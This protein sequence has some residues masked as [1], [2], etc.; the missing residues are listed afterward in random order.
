[1]RRWPLLVASLALLSLPWPAAAEIGTIDKVPAATLLFPYFEVDVADPDGVNTLIGIQNTS[2]TAAL[3]HVTLWTDL[4]YPTFSWN[5]YLTGYDQETIDLR[6]LFVGRLVPITASDGQDPPDT[7]SPQG[8]FSQD[9]NF[10]TCSG[11]PDDFGYG[12]NGPMWTMPAYAPALTPEWA[13]DLRAAHMGLASPIY[14]HGVC[15]ARIHGDT[16]ARGYVTVDTVW[17]CTMIDPSVLS[18]FYSGGTGNATNQNVL[19]GDYFVVNPGLGTMEADDAVHIEASA[20][21]PLTS[22]PGRYTFYGSLSS[23]A[24]AAS[25]NREPLP[26]AWAVSYMAERSALRVWRDPGIPLAPFVCGGPLPAPYNLS[27]TQIAA[28]DCE[29]AATPLAGTPFPSAAVAVAVGGTGI[30]AAGKCGWL[31]LNLNAPVAGGNFG[32]IRQS[33]VTVVR[34]PEGAGQLSTGWSGVQLGNAAHSDDP[35]IN[36]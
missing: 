35:G 14:L 24:G 18:Y 5:L 20:T 36:Q 31:F 21:D 17:M 3:A 26:T 1:M 12:D 15:G 11:E 13:A 28:L 34:H 16:L 29:G 10:A 30:P 7:I 4:G 6:E 22:Q 32:R 25:D 19:V 8:P 2:A 33:W 27:Q 9:I 23:V